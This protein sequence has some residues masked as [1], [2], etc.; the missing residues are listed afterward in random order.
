M[1]L[2]SFDELPNDFFIE[3]AVLNIFF[4]N[5]FIVKNV[6]FLLHPNSFYNLSHRI[7]YET[8]KNILE[9]H[10]TFNLTYFISSLQDQKNFEKIGGMEKIIRLLNKSENPTDLQNYIEILNEKLYRRI[11]IEFG[12]DIVQLSYSS[13]ESLEKI[14]EKIDEKLFFLN[15]QK[16][17]QKTY[18]ASEVI[19]EV[20]QEIKEK[21]S[22]QEKIGFSTNFQELDDLLNGIQKSDLIIIAGRPSMG[23]TAL[24]L[25]IGKNIVEN[26][27]IPLILFSL[28]MSR[29]Q[30]I[31]RFLS[32]EANIDSNRLKNGKMTLL[33]WKYL[34]KAMKKLSEFSIFIDDNSDLSLPQIRSS[35]QKIFQ[36]KKKKDS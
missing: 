7:I 16:M 19:N 12:K 2:F 14:L 11:L 29:Q 15:Q 10:L 28:E 8:M 6:F 34:S 26:Y 17:F 20:Y 5:P 3:E 21:I 23:K 30:I 24:A 25:N 1:N 36:N 35:I 31:Y 33:E 22:K 9:K 13:K 18:K 4:L 27:R 32:S